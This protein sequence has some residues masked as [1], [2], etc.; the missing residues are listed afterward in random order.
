MSNYIHDRILYFLKQHSPFDLLSESDLKNL[1]K[2][3]KVSYHNKN[4]IVFEKNQ[5]PKDSFFVV[6]EGLVGIFDVEENSI[7]VDACEIGDF[8]GIRP[9]FGKE[10]YLYQAKC[11]QSSILLAIP[12]DKFEINLNKQPEILTF[13]LQVFANQTS[14]RKKTSEGIPFTESLET[15]QNTVIQPSSIITLSPKNSIQQAAKLMKKHRIGSVVIVNDH[16]FPVGIITD[17]DFRN[18]VVAENLNV[19]ESVMQI[20]SHP[21]YTIGM[22]EKMSDYH[23]KMIQNQIRHLVVTEDGTNQSK[24]VGILS[25][26]DLLQSYQDS[27]KNWFKAVRKAKNIDEIIDIQQK[28]HSYLSQNISDVSNFD[29]QLKVFSALQQKMIEKCVEFSLEKMPSPPPCAFAFFQIGSLGRS[30]QLLLSDQDNALVFEEDSSA[31]QAYFLQLG[32]AIVE[33]IKNLGYEYCPAKMMANQPEWN[34][35]L[36]EWKTTFQHW[37]QSPSEHSVML[38]QIFFDIGFVSGE[39]TL[40]KKLA[41]H[42]EILLHNNSLF[43]AYL[44]KEATNFPP[45]F[46]LFKQ[47]TTENIENNA[48]AFDLKLK[49]IMPLV[50]AIRLLALDKKQVNLAASTQRLNYLMSQEENNREIFQAIKESFVHALYLRT[51]YGLMH[52]NSG[53]FLNLKELNKSELLLLKTIVKNLQ[54]LQELI[55]VRF[56]LN[57]LS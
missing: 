17:K 16:N 50:N 47:W 41:E 35:S 14:K 10:N 18:K 34:Q 45:A 22:Q 36:E 24:V 48:N 23:V 11:I 13:F 3:I 55:T 5:P 38:S 8:F 54:Q 12:F 26:H 20:A 6:F 2:T 21:V 42:I 46:N 25:E 33:N 15:S 39:I 52:Q 30:E 51:K 9:Y 29:Y 40:T 27:P 49:V 53:R 37:I 28:I 32:N 1:I 56:Q 4:E 44:G 57:F 43:K 19:A 31:N 7:C